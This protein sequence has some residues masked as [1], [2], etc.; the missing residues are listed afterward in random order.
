[1]ND[2]F[3]AA[4]PEDRTPGISRFLVPFLTGLVIVLAVWSGFSYM[5]AL[6]Y[7]RMMESSYLRAVDEASANLTNISTDLVKGMYAGSPSQ[8]SLISSKLWKEASS[9]KA[10]LGALPVAQLHLDNTYRFLSQVGDYAMYLSRKAMTGQEITSQERQQFQQLREY[11]ERLTQQVASLEQQ[12][13]AGEVT[14]EEIERMVMDNSNGA[15]AEN[16]TEGDMPATGGLDAMEQ[17]FTGY[18]TLIYDGPFSDHIMDK[19]PTMTKGA[20]EITAEKAKEKALSAA[21]QDVELESYREE[22]SRLPSHIFYSDQHSVAVTKNGGY[23]CY[24]TGP[25]P[26]SIEP[27]LSK[28]DALR[29][30]QNYLASLGIGSMKETYYEIH[31]GIMTI[32]FAHT[33]TDPEVTCYTDLI[34]VD[35]SME[36]G[37]ILAFDARGYLVNH[38]ERTFTGPQLTEEQAR[39]KL[40]P[41]LTVN[42]SKLALIPTQGQNEVFVYEFN[43]TGTAGDQVLVYINANTGAEEQI[44]ILLENEN[45]TLTK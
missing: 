40:S 15:E 16:S 22:D 23:L 31:D 18:P 12:L 17:G 2:N 38:Q 8:M 1:M 11:A 21:G 43:C 27:V 3:E 39:E 13:S 6:K 30:A 28:D 37:E 35:V 41:S 25:K 33:E 26:D 7:R 5:R 36:D 9:A 32:N 42:S 44:L 29:S 14:F 20:E 19:E 34:K 4:R 24:V 45:G 10:S